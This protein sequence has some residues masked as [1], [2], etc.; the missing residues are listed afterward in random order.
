MRIRNTISWVVLVIVIAITV[1]VL[2]KMQDVYDWFALRNYTPSSRVAKLADDTTMN[3][4]T[5]KVFYVNHPELNNK[6]EFNGHC[7]TTEQSIVLGC[8]I[9]NKG[10][11]LL[12]VNDPR[13]NGV[14]E[15]TA[16]HEVLHAAY[17]RLD[18]KEREKVDKMVEEFFATIKDERIKTTVANYKDKDPSVVPNELHSILGTEVSELSPELEQYYSKYFNNRKQIAKFSEQYEKTFVEL[19]NQVEELDSELDSIKRQID[20]NQAQLDSK[21]QQIDNER[22]KLDSLLSA[23]QIEE[24]NS[25]VNG[26]NQ[27]VSSYNSLINQTKQLINEYNALVERRNSLATQEQD[28]VNS[29]DSTHLTEQE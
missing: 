1:G 27:L 16:A 12:D 15:V 23:K 25:R 22:S 18:R 19:R 28:L 3:D 13:L 5:R 2:T 11:F 14:M 4:Y 20:N 21:N 26:F 7:R 6:T 10:I 9:E 29:I 8:F 17:E 24:Y